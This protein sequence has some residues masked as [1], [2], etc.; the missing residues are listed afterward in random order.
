MMMM[1]EKKKREARGVKW[2]IIITCN[3][4]EALSNKSISDQNP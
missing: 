3:Y 4:E 2:P 1:D